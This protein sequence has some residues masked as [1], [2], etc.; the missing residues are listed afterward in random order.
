MTT[1]LNPHPTPNTNVHNGT[2]R[3]GPTPYDVLT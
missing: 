2:T 1:E 3:N